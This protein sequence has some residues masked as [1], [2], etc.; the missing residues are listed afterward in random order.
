MHSRVLS[1][2]SE[3]HVVNFEEKE[4]FKTKKSHLRC[5]SHVGSQVGILHPAVEKYNYHFVASIYMDTRGL[6]FCFPL[7]FH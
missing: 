2:S 6:S 4:V 5:A 7:S 3:G 1:N